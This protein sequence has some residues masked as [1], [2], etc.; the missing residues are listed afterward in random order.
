MKNILTI[1]KRE[2]SSY[3]NSPIAYIFIIAILAICSGFYMFFFFF[4]SG[5]AEMR[6]FFS[7]NAWLMLFFL[8]AITM[9]LWADDQKTG[10]IALL[11][12]LPMKSYELVGGKYLAG[13][14]FYALYLAGTLP[15]PIA[16]SFLGRPDWGPI[17]GGYLGL[18]FL[19]ALYS[20]IGLFFSGLF[21]DQI[22]SWVLA[23][24]GC[25]VLHLL[26]WLPVA[27]QLDS[28][29]GGFG[30][31]LQRAVGSMAHF[32]NMYKGVITINDIVYFVSFSLVFLTLNALTVE[33]RM[34]RQADVKF[35]TS[36][37][38]LIAVVA[39][40]N[41]VVYRLP[42]GRFD[43]TQG[44]IYTVSKSARNILKDLKTKVTI[45][46]YVT[47]EDK[48]PAG[49][50]DLQRDISDKLGE[51]TQISD[52]IKYEVIDPTA[53]PDAAKTLEQKGISPFTLRTAERD[54]VGI[55]NV[56]S[57]LAISYLDK[58]DDIISQVMP[59]TLPTL[60]Y[61]ICSRIYRLT[62]QGKANVA[63]VAGY[64]PVDQ[65][66]NDPRVRQMMMQRGQ[67]IPEKEDRYKNLTSTFQQLGYNVSRIDLSS[68]EVLPSDTRT[69]LVFAS[70]PLSDRQR[71]EIAKALYSGKNVILAAQEYKYNYN[72]LKGTNVMIMPAKSDPGVNSL[73]SNYGVT[74]G[75]KILMDDQNQIVTIQTQ[76][77]MMGFLPVA[78]PVDVQ[79][80]VQIKVVPENMNS[81]YAFTSNLGPMV[82]LW[83][84][85]LKIDSDK[86]SKLG[87]KATVL[88]TSSSKS[89]ESDS[90]GGPLSAD[91]SRPSH[92]VG[93]QPL[94]VMIIG[95]FP[96]PYANQPPP[97]WQD[98]PDS[99]PSPS[100]PET[101][102]EAPGKLLLI[103]ASDIFGDQFIP[104]GDYQGQ[105]PSHEE[106][107]LKAVEG[108]TLSED[109]LQI[110]NKAVQI[111]ALKSTSPFAKI[112][113]RI[114]TILLAPA[115]IITIGIAR[116]LMR[117]KRRQM[118]RAMLDQAGGGY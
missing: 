87:L 10:S 7:I 58:P 14:A 83:G 88:F 23:V 109:L 41:L 100:Q 91:N 9:R 18:L 33:Q 111:R 25:L 3:F 2:F 32:E 70:Q 36:A 103:G 19:G 95:Q 90:N 73:L 30:T 115:I 97:K 13:L 114:F 20:S 50:K 60:E 118:Y 84:S 66:Y 40:L 64:D 107:I 42:L 53:N 6:D 55:K 82:Y 93:R 108:L 110:S 76:G 28:W 65:R 26:G 21:K 51:F 77:T 96:N 17:F 102:A 61:E 8:P 48:M 5:V 79:S 37:A 1:F 35:F 80:P 27:A 74:L 47:P 4:S 24:I 99:L 22:T 59:A 71:Y 52:R 101:F 54:A 112:L 15:I 106:L 98:E 75:D 29:I 31:F 69:L 81:D 12:S 49:M 68:R 34:R 117:Q 43:T 86:I 62:Q 78:I 38:V 57:T 67:Q 85:P 94:A 39:M 16:I 56:Y 113:W 11:Q 44:K 46:Y 45:R 104:G 63:V 92:Y 116:M 105:K 72:P 89:W